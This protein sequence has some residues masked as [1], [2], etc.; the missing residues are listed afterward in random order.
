MRPAGIEP[1]SL[2]PESR[3]PMAP[4]APWRGSKKDSANRAA[5]R[6][7]TS[8]AP[9]DTEGSALTALSYYWGVLA[10]YPIVTK[11]FKRGPWSN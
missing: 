8:C 3:S 2:D 9:C 4:G 11:P 5:P 7:M 6:Y 1:R 10:T